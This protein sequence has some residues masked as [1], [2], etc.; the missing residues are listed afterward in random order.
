MGWL[1]SLASSIDGHVGSVMAKPSV[2]GKLRANKKLQK[3]NKY[4][5]QNLREVAQT[6]ADRL[7]NATK[8]AV[9]SGNGT[10]Y[11]W[12]VRDVVYDE[13]DGVWHAYI[14]FDGPV[15]RPSLNPQNDGVTNILGLLNTGFQISPGKNPPSG[16][17]HGKKIV[18]LR[19]RPASNFLTDVVDEFKTKYDG[20][21]SIEEIGTLLGTSQN[22]SE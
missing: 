15:T 4:A 14:S 16:E 8:D 22:D 13:A 20:K 1:E 18:G 21:Y 11:T 19:S 17:W 6:F 2:A 9:Y 5:E 12:L 10:F 7:T 3:N